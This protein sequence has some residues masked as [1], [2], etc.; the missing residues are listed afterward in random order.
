[1]IKAL[2]KKTSFSVFL[3]SFRAGGVEMDR[4]TKWFIAA[5]FFGG[6]SLISVFFIEDLARW[7][8][9]LNKRLLFVCTILIFIFILFSFGSLIKANAKRKVG[10]IAASFIAAVIP[11]AALL[12]NGLIFT[13]YFIGK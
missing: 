4:F 8:G 2:N 5:L 9:E 11:V 6:A 13:I 12:M 1:M 10:E 7:S 3:H